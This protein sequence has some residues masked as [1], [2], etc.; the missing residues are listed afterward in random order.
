[1]SMKNKTHEKIGETFPNGA[2]TVFEIT[3]QQVRF[4]SLGG[5]WQQRL[6]VEEFYKHFREHDPDNKPKL[7][8]SKFELDGMEEILEGYTYGFLWNGFEMPLF[9][10]DEALKLKADMPIEFDEESNEIIID[11]DP[12]GEM[13]DPDMRFERCEAKMHSYDGHPIELFPIGDSWTWTRA[14]EED[15]DQ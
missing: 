14:V 8:K 9:T 5:G 7:E 15:D 1:M 3:D 10:K 11:M 12:T 13:V 6:P 2:V 4:H